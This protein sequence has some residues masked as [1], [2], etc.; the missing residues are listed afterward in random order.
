MK[1]ERCFSFALK[2]LRLKTTIPG[3]FM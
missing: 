2:P 1:Q 3:F